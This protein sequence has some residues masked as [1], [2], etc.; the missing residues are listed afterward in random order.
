MK[1]SLVFLGLVTLASATSS[2][3]TS[4]E[5]MESL[6]SKFGEIPGKFRIPNC[7]GERNEKTVERDVRLHVTCLL[8]SYN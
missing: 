5:S 4:P 8:F 1:Y 2:T 3:P 7:R 6:L